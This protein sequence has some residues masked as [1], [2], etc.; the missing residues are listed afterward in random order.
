M[1][2][3]V[4]P[5]SG[6]SL[7]GSPT[8]IGMMKAR[9]IP[10]MHC[11]KFLLCLSFR[12]VSW[13]ISVWV[14]MSRLH[15]YYWLSLCRCS[16]LVGFVYVQKIEYYMRSAWLL[17]HIP[18]LPLPPLRVYMIIPCPIH[19]V[20]YTLLFCWLLSSIFL[21]QLGI[22]IRAVWTR[23]KLQTVEGR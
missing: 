9:T 21:F 16:W 12:L 14:S 22:M 4:K 6:L 19:H 15:I 7:S 20:M 8:Y 3:E 23:D 1:S 2:M 13:D 17:A 5:F 10:E 18:S 11:K